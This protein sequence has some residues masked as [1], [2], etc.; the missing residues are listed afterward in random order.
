MEEEKLKVPVYEGMSKILE[1]VNASYLCRLMGVHTSWISPR[2]N[3]RIDTNGFQYAY[4]PEDVSR[5]NQTLPLLANVILNQ[6]II[7]KE[8][9]ADR[10]AVA[11]HIKEKVKPVLILRYLAVNRM[12]RDRRWLEK[13]TYIPDKPNIRRTYFTPTD[14]ADFN[15]SFQE[16]I[17][18]LRG[19]TL[20]YEP[21]KRTL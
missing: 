14:A 20:E 18:Y 15:S 19:I 4:T 6:C 9:Y 11:I 10:E 13:R 7:P 8:L 16:I 1:V 3:Q 17:L 12:G 2:Q 5:L 21:P